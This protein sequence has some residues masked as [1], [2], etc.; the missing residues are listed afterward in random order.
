ML[1]D[2]GAEVIKIERPGEGDPS[3]VT[4]A[5]LPGDKGGEKGGD[6][7]AFASVNRNKKSVTLDFAQDEGRE[8]L[9]GLAA[10]ADILI[11]NYIPGTLARYGLDYDSIKAINPG[12]IYCSMTGFGQTGPSRELPGYDGVFQAQSGIM[13]VTG[14]PDGVPG[15]GPMKVG[16][17]V[18]D[19][20]AG[21][22]LVAGALAALHERSRSGLGQHIDVA[23]AEVAMASMVFK[24]QDYLQTGTIEPRSGNLYLTKG[25][26]STLLSCAD[27]DVILSCNTDQ[28]YAGFCKAME[29]PDMASDPRFLKGA[30]R[31]ENIQALQAAMEARTRL[32]PRDEVV[33]RCR[34]EGVPVAPVNDFA[35]ALADPQAVHRD[36]TVKLPHPC[37]PELRVIANPIRMSRTPVVYERHPPRLGEHSAE[38]LADLGVD[39]PRLAELKTKGIV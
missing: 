39:A 38:V 10:R 13:D 17:Q 20:M 2:F 24:L 33:A 6:T 5:R 7:T 25:W 4:G 21:I 12:I 1:G 22:Q 3:R 15:G 34:A 23:L 37:D 8:L 26:M 29:A 36:M 11:E 30:L 9:L 18:V 31:A 35:A 28:Q 19:Y 27:H 14:L 16:F 32:R